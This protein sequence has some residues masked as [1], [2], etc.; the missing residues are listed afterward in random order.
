[1]VTK[2]L[3]FSHMVTGEEQRSFG[4]SFRDVIGGGSVSAGYRRVV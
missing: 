4:S 1:M 2:E 3:G